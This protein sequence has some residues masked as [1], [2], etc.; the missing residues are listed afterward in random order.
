MNRQ[1]QR[2]LWRGLLFC[3]V[4][5]G[6]MLLLGGPPLFVLGCFLLLLGVTHI[7]HGIVRLF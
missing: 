1:A 7:A 6:F 2:W 3:I 5:L 4:G